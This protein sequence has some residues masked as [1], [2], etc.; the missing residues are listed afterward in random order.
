MLNFFFDIEK[1]LNAVQE[2]DS[3]H[4][5]EHKHKP[6][7]EHT[8]KH[9]LEYKSNSHSKPKSKPTRKMAY[10]GP[11]KHEIYYQI[12]K[13]NGAHP[14]DWIHLVQTTISEVDRAKVKS[15]E[16]HEKFMRKNY[17]ML[18]RTTEVFIQ[19]L[20]KI[21]ELE[22]NE[23]AMAMDWDL[24]IQEAGIMVSLLKESKL[25]IG[26]ELS[27]VAKEA[28]A[29]SRKEYNES[30]RGK[31][32]ATFSFLGTSSDSQIARELQKQEEEDFLVRVK[33]V[34][35]KISSSFI[36]HPQQFRIHVSTT[37]P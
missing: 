22:T 33:K 3:Q 20:N 6:R 29:E 12:A 18:Q 28:K 14:D 13:Y 17:S 36:I 7:S 16:S 32:S 23:Q 26:V 35:C 11:T 27:K 37:R 1:Y 30:H 31:G 34:R 5:H 24:L 10:T 9:R 25:E 2:I 21:M 4:K 8:S 19:K 15:L